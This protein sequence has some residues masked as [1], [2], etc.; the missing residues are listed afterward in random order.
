M[1]EEYNFSE[2]IQNPYAKAP[3]LDHKF[4][5][6]QPILDYF[7]LTT[8]KRPGQALKRVNVDFP[9]WMVEALDREAQR[10]GIHRQALIKTWIGQRLDQ[11][12]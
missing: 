10:L 6:G 4:D 8:A 12:Q 7:D 3:E 11:I 1:R 9:M 2:S 5:Q